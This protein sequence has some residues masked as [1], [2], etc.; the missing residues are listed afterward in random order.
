[1]NKTNFRVWY[2]ISGKRSDG[3]STDFR[4]MPGDTAVSAGWNK[5]APNQP[6]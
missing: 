3:S 5:W 6:S 4:W 2:W 1:M